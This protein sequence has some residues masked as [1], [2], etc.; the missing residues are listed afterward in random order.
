[1]SNILK[2]LIF[3]VNTNS[4]TFKVAEK[5]GLVIG[6]AIRYALIGSGVVLL[7]GLLKNI[8]PSHSMSSVSATFIVIN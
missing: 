7:G 6:K 3:M 5:V 1:M 4:P 8:R 2:I